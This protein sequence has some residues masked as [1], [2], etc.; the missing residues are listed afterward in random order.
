MHQDTV[1]SSANNKEVLNELL[2]MRRRTNEDEDPPITLLHGQATEKLLRDTL[3]R[4]K[5]DE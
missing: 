2:V 4:I 1:L 5:I 3:L